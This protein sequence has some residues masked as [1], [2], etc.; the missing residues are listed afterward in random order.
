MADAPTKVLSR[1]FKIYANTGTEGAPTWTQVKGLG[2]D[3]IAI[4]P[5]SSDVDFADAD[6]YRRNFPDGRIGSNP[7]LSSAEAGAGM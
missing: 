1:D 4:S 2:D 7:G 5:S 3:G 6:D